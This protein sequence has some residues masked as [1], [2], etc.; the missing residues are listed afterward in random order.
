M[1]RN[2]LFA[3]LLFGVS[4]TAGAQ[5]PGWQSSGGN[6]T[7]SD[8]VGIGTTAPA[9]EL[10]VKDTTGPSTIRLEGLADSGL[11]IVADR[12]WKIGVN[13]AAAGAGKFTLY[14]VTSALHRL[15]IDTA[16]NTGIGT[17]SP[18]AKLHVVGNAQFDGTVTGT[19]IK[20]HYQDVAEWVP[21]R[22]DLEPGTVVVLDKAVGNAV[23]AS[24]RAYDTTV[25]GVV[26]AQP[27]LILGVEGASKEQV[28][29]TG[30]VRVKVDASHGAIAV[31][32]LLVTS[33]RPGFAMRSTPLDLAGTAIHRPGTIIGKALEP[34]ASGEGEILVLLS[35]Q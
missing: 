33:D 21:S 19:Y 26:S 3:V 10:H 27:G 12:D 32:D 28:A 24:S 4:L 17:A 31:G 15:V 25:A 7:T 34:L 14:D 30:R 2:A 20:A 13:I 16:G 6:T 18:A 22:N 8:K 11:R 5:T 23:M 1:M 35:L 29:T 9:N